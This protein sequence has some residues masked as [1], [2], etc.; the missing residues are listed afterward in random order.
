MAGDNNGRI[1]DQHGSISNERVSW[2]HTVGADFSVA[3]SIR[4][5]AHQFDGIFSGFDFVRWSESADFNDRCRKKLVLSGPV[6]DPGT[7]GLSVIWNAPQWSP[8]RR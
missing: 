7:G 5:V 8:F 3:N 2:L 4:D 1:Y 6:C